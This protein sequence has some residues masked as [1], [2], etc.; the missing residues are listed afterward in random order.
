L[1]GPAGAAIGGPLFASTPGNSRERCRR[2]H[3]A[4]RDEQ[5]QR[6]AF[7]GLV[8]DSATLT[9]VGLIVADRAH[10]PLVS[11]HRDD[12]RAVSHRRLL[13]VPLFGILH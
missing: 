10:P 8:A 11:F 5:L 9:P 4:A 1:T 2:R 13:R 6:I 7:S 3:T 12:R